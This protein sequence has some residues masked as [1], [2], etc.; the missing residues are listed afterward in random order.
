MG[1]KAWSDDGLKIQGA[2]IGAGDG[3]FQS[4]KLTI[5]PS[6]I[7]DGEILL[8]GGPVPVGRY[9]VVSGVSFFTTTKP[10]AWHRFWARILLGWRWSDEP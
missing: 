9:E 8:W 4:G 2:L 7:T 10:H 5:S 3:A 1:N 6:S